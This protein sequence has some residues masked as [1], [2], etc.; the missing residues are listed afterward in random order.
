MCQ[1]TKQVSAFKGKGQS[2]AKE[3]PADSIYLI[4]NQCCDYWVQESYD[5][6]ISRPCAFDDDLEPSWSSTTILIK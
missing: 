6:R 2:F 5:L 3:R 4:T 1:L